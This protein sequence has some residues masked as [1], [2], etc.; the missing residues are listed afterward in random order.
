MEI[1]LSDLKK[2]GELNKKSSDQSFKVST[3]YESISST[4]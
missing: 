4:N 1:Y 2:M 3:I